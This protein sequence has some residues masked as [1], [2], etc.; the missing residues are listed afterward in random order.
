MINVNLIRKDFPILDQRVNGQKLIYFDNAATSQTPNQVVQSIVDYYK[1][2]NSNI[3]RGTHKLS[4][5]AT[6]AYEETRGKVQKYFNTKLPQEII[7]TSGTTQS[8]NIITLGY[9]DLLTSEDEVIV[10]EMEHHSNIVPIQMLCERTG[11]RLNVIP[12][13]EQ[14]NLIIS[15]F[16]KV[17][18]EKTKLVFISHVSNAL[19]TVNPISEII[20]KSHCMGAK[21]LVD[22]AQGASHFEIDL[23]KLDVDYYTVSAHKM[24]GPT[25]VGVLYGKEELLE[26]LSPWHGGGEMIDEVSFEKT[27]YGKLPH[28]FEPGTPNIAGVI[29]FGSAIEYINNIGLKN[30]KAYEDELLEYSTVELKKIEGLKIYGEAKNKTSV[31]SFNVEGIHHYDLGSLLDQFGVAVRIG[32][33]CAQPVM[34]YFKIPGTVRMSFSFYN[35]KEEINIMIQALKQAIKMLQ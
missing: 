23:Q 32:H 28:K 11:A 3:H 26:K 33:H 20:K 13:D 15:E 31:I 24:Y 17:L 1:Q 21:V 25:G 12:M 14:G 6:T 16:D 2:T 4:I 9:T 8:I 7:F 18:S 10:S 27:T 35:T 34:N 5:Q 19:G 22:G 30:I 29:A